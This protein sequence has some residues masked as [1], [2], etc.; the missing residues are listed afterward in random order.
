MCSGYEAHGLKKHGLTRSGCMLPMRDFFG[1]C[2][3]RQGRTQEFLKG[4][5]WEWGGGVK[6]RGPVVY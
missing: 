5:G 6:G 3:T 4:V 2:H 1:I